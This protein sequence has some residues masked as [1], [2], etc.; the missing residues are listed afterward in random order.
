MVFPEVYIRIT[1]MYRTFCDFDHQ[2][3][4]KLLVEETPLGTVCL[5][6]SRTFDESQTYTAWM[7]KV[8]LYAGVYVNMG[9]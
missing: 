3:R 5:W 8:D 7:K 1:E 4:P 2:V 6:F 9:H